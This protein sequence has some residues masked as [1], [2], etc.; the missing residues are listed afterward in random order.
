MVK[1]SGQ[2]AGSSARNVVTASVK[3]TLGETAA[4][5]RSM[6]PRT[7]V[8]IA[9]MACPCSL[10]GA[11]AGQPND[12]PVNCSLPSMVLRLSA[13]SPVEV[14]PSI[15]RTDPLTMV[16]L[17]RSEYPSGLCSRAPWAV[18]LPMVAPRKL[19]RPPSVRRPSR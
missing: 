10:Y 1:R 8:D 9:S 16:W 2:V 6:P 5:P 17:R 13:T 14:K 3:S 18:R 19:T 11:A 4:Q 12:P 15:S 7:V